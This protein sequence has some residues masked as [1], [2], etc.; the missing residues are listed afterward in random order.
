MK[1][2]PYLGIPEPIASVSKALIDGSDA[3]HRVHAARLARTAMLLL[4]NIEKSTKM[5]EIG[6]SGFFPLLCKELA[7]QLEVDVT[8]FDKNNPSCSNINMSLGKKNI[9]VKAFAVDLEFDKIPIN[10]KTYDIVLCCEVLEHMEVDP[11]FMLDE[12]NRVLKNNGLLIL[13]TPNITSSRALQKILNGVEPY[14]YMQYHRD[15]SYN[16][17]NYEYSAPGLAKLLN[18]AGFKGKIW[19]EDLFEDG[20]PEIVRNLRNF[21]FKAE[22]VGDNLISVSQK[23]CRPTERYPSGIYS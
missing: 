1:S 9:E 16:R 5:L 7:P 2:Q 15:K 13:T 4:E 18:A 23:Y 6:T 21:G 10:D 17:H 11:M 3:Y 20:L 8:H 22:H 19:S 14:F 12:V